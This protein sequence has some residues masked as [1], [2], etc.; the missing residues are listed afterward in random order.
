LRARHAEEVGR[1]QADVATLREQRD[2]LAI[3][4]DEARRRVSELSQSNDDYRRQV[5]TVGETVGRLWQFEQEVAALQGK[6]TRLQMQL[7]EQ[8]RQAEM[9]A[10]LARQLHADRR[11]I[12]SH[13]R[14]LY[15]AAS[16][17][18]ERGLAAVK[19]AA[20]KNQL[21][22]RLEA[23]RGSGLTADAAETLEKAEALLLRLAMLPEGDPQSAGAWRSAVQSSGVVD[24]IDKALLA[25]PPPGLSQWLLEARAIFAEAGHV[26]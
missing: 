20:R 5:A 11:R 1:L 8:S 15:L 10:A 25:D 18:G 22:Q 9:A 26:G 2:E 13:M 4:A 6:A 3:V 24:E 12:L 21:L 19:L 17:P 14:D 16:A 7:G 23:L